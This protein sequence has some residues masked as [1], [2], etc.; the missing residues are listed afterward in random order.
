MLNETECEKC[1]NWNTQNQ[2]TDICSDHGMEIKVLFAVT[3]PK[4]FLGRHP[5]GYANKKHKEFSMGHPTIYPTGVT[6]FKPEKCWGGY[7][8]F[9][10]QEIGA[11]LMDMNGRE[12]NV[13]K[14]VH[15]MPNK[16]LPGGYLVTSR[17]P[18]A[19]NTVCRMA[20]TLSRWIGTAI[21]SGNSTKTNLLRIPA[22]PA[23]GWPAITTIFSVKATPWA[24]TRPAWSPRRW[25]AK[26]W[27]L[28]TAMCAI[29]QSATSSSWTI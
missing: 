23:A 13:W 6:L 15:G 17:G 21:L 1:C 29:A 24:T 4:K 20:L 25:K 8:I 9:Q 16:I 18:A 2:Q 10:A 28:P 7:T 3:I 26:P 14:G 11:V 27:S 19:A 12:V 5:Q 22:S